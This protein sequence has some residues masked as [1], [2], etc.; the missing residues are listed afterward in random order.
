MNIIERIKQMSP[1]DLAALGLQ[2]IAYIRPVTTAEGVKVFSINAADGTRLAIAATQAQAIAA[3][4][5]HELEP[6]SVH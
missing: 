2:G 1:G 3:I 4:R 6:V 5:E